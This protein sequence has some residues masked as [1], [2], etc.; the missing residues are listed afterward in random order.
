M[1]NDVWYRETLPQ[2]SKIQQMFEDDTYHFVD[3]DLPVDSLPQLYD[4]MPWY[5][6][7]IWMK[8]ILP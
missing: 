2:I 4:D 7:R 5:V 8:T 3:N 1:K 6:N